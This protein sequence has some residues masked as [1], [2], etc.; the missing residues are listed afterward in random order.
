MRFT[1]LIPLLL[2]ACGSGEPLQDS[3][4]LR[5][6]GEESDSGDTA[7][8]PD[9]PT[10]PQGVSTLAGSGAMTTIDGVGAEAAFHEPKAM[11]LSPDG[12]LYV[13]GMTDAVRVV[14]MDGEVRSLAFDGPRPSEVAGMAFGP[15]G[16]LYLSDNA[17]HC[18]LRISEGASQVFAGTCGS[19]GFADGAVALFHRPR[20]LSFDAD[21]DLILADSENMRLRSIDPDGVASTLAGID[22]FSGPTEGPVSTA[23][24]YFPLDVAIAD[25]GV[26]YFSGLDNCIRRVAAGQVEDVAG[27]CQN[28]SSLGTNDGSAEAARFTAPFNIAFD[29][30]GRLIISDSFNSRIRVLSADR[31]EVS[32]LTGD[33]P[34]YRDGA[35][36]EALFDVTRGIAIDRGD[37]LFVA[38]SVN[39]LVRVVV[40]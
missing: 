40:E 32:T 4:A 2:S 28:Y 12:D 10:F 37:N 15:D 20:G 19:P 33:T 34:G 22:S 13:A 8:D 21:G 14:S 29:S 31:T 25:D 24:V 39:N 1:I 18:I 16:A 9:I 11:A 5:D 27:L 3:I 6:T 7:A 17:Q 38:D 36:D 26:V 35:L 30:A 23:M